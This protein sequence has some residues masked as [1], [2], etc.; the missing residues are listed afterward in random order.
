[1]A[2]QESFDHPE[3]MCSTCGRSVVQA[4]IAA[5]STGARPAIIQ[6]SER[7]INF[8]CGRAMGK[9]CFTYALDRGAQLA[10]AALR[11]LCGKELL[12]QTQEV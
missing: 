2:T 8:G 6:L 9:R 5:N 12:G 4:A 11:M 3:Q 10:T 1:M 7:I